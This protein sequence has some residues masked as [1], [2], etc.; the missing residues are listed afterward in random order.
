MQLINALGRPVSSDAHMAIFCAL[1]NAA[2]RCFL[3]FAGAVQFVLFS[4]AAVLFLFDRE[5]QS[6]H[7]SDI[8]P[9]SRMPSK[10][11]GLLQLSSGRCVQRWIKLFV[12]QLYSI[13]FNPLLLLILYLTMCALRYH[14]RPELQC[15]LRQCAA[16]AETATAMDTGFFIRV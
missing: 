4:H 9:Q 11:L 13:Q 7:H 16:I 2:M 5:Q 1:F 10:T 6:Q 3:L 14:G 15:W 12:S 8:A